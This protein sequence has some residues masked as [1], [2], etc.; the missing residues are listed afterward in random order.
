MARYRCSCG[1]T[2]CGTTDVDRRGFLRTIAA[3]AAGLYVG[4]GGMKVSAAPQAVRGLS[5]AGV[6]ARYPMTPP[7][8]Y[9]GEHLQH[10]RMP[11]GG[12]GTGTIW[13]DGDGRLGVWQIFNNYAEERIPDSFFAI[14]AE[15]D[16]QEP[17]LRVLQT[18]PEAGFPAMESLTYEGGYPIARLAFADD[19]LPVEVKLEALNPMIPLDTQS[20][21]IP[22]ALF[23]ITARNPGDRRVRASILASAQNA[24][25]SRGNGEQIAGT[26]YQGYG[27]NRNSLVAADDLTAILMHRNAS[28]PA[29]GPMAVRDRNGARVDGP[30]VLWAAELQGPKET[31]L[32]SPAATEVLETA[33]RLAKEGGGIVAGHARPSFFAGLS[34]ARDRVGALEDVE[35]FDDFEDGTYAKWTVEGDAFGKAPHTGTSPG[36]NPV[37]G[38]RGERLVNSFVPNDGPQGRMLSQAF[39][40]GRAYIGFLIGGGDH[41]RRCCMNLLVDGQIVR[42]ATGRNNEQLEP[43]SWNV[44]DLIGKEARFEIVDRN[45]EGWGHINIDHI[46]FADV[47]PDALI[48]LEGPVEALSEFLAASIDGAEPGEATGGGLAALTADG[49]AALGTLG[50]WSL[51][52]YTRLTGL[53]KAAVL[54]EAPN[55]DPVVVEL[56]MGEATLVFSLAAGL[57]AD[58]IDACLARARGE[59]LPAGARFVPTSPDWGTMALAT[60]GA[61]AMAQVRWTDGE[62]LAASFATLGRISGRPDSGESPT[63]QTYNCALA[64][65]FELAP[66]EERSVTFILTWH[67]P[68]VDRLGHPGNLYCR[69]FGDALAAA[70]HVARN[71]DALWDTTVLYQTTLYQSNLPEEFID[72]MSSQSVILRGPT[73]WWDETGYFGGFEGCYAC[74]PLNCTHVWNYAQT[75][76]RLFPEVGR[77]IRVSDLITYLH[78]SGET[79]HRHF[80]DTGAFIDGHCAVIEAT[81]REHQMSGDNEFI[82]RVWSGLE[83]AV[84]WMIGQFDAEHHGVPL[85]HQ[86]NT[87]DCAVSGPNTF[88]GSQYLSALAAAERL[89]EAVNDEGAAI[90]WRAVREAGMKLQN[91]TLWGGEYYIQH[92]QEPPANDYGPGCHSDQLLGQWWAHMLDLGYLYPTDRVR[93]ALRS[94]MEQNFRTDFHGFDQAPRRYVLDDEGGLLMCTW[95]KGGRPA[96]FTIYSDE[97]WTGIEYSTA[98]L[99]VFEGLIEEARTIV[100][101]ARSR[102]DGRLRDGL[103]SGPGGNPFNDLECGKFYARAMSS[104]GL[105]I[106][107]QGL[108]LDGPKG[109]IGFRPR[110][111]PE[112]HRSSF[113][114]PEGWGLFVQRREEREQV[115]ALEV[116]YG[117]LRV[118]E[119]VLEL[120][121]GVDTSALT[122]RVSAPGGA[123]KVRCTVDGRDVRV[124]LADQVS[125][126]AGQEIEARISW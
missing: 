119:L 58:W 120:P 28:P 80:A 105:L 57:P 36:Q 53:R 22:C 123:L 125:I 20:S 94:I 113:T 70:E 30:E 52:A 31:A 96:S 81:L 4:L 59:A 79:R 26:A 72:A 19:V 95:P 43:G 121:E 56:K 55:G 100:R 89:A 107:S 111:Q 88:I 50:A 114:A 71:L 85:G 15:R 74:C 32:G 49:R 51:G 75:H 66:G 112:D 122:V 110:W 6:L 62:A 90:R 39:R 13:L 9:A 40:I 64:V 27:G 102:Y 109:I 45:S 76:G 63:G 69:R 54:A 118:K 47:P 83:K 24:V 101:T 124:K 35:V 41:A 60:T 73:C 23:R 29:S 12:I 78:E 14:R 106:A 46:V 42:T 115:A 37:S 84:D 33:V 104:W 91:E 82:R 8:V 87:Y 126:E 65:P 97:V 16:G 44:A 86:W 11:I 61:P 34:A 99:M 2:N 10:V 116:R 48:R 68:N 5:L 1:R 67:F 21:S 103:N 38:F 25:G 117:R 108:V 93:T 77:N 98:G 7:R 92:I 3:G 18:T 17:I